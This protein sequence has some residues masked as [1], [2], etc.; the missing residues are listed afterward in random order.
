MYE[1]VKL[2]KCNNHAKFEMHHLHECLRKL[3]HQNFCHI[4]TVG[5]PASP[6][7]IITWTHI[8]HACKQKGWLIHNQI[9]GILEHHL[10]IFRNWMQQKVTINSQRK[11]SIY[12]KYANVNKKSLIDQHSYGICKKK[13]ATDKQR[14]HHM[15]S[16]WVV[17]LA[18]MVGKKRNENALP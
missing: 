1:W 15:Q 2:N 14:Y 4:Q 6:T 11:Q 8:F 9:S 17:Q 7:L 18:R 16:A 5:R 13:S 3:Q 10:T 12:N